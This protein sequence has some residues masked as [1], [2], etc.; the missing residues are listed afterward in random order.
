MI[1]F[2]I[3]TVQYPAAWWQSLYHQPH[4]TTREWTQE[5]SISIWIQVDNTPIVDLRCKFLFPD[6]AVQLPPIHTQIYTSDKKWKRHRP[7]NYPSSEREPSLHT[8]SLFINDW[9]VIIK[10]VRPLNPFTINLK[11]RN[12]ELNL[13][14]VYNA[15]GP[16]S[17][18]IK[19]RSDF[20]ESVSMSAC[21]TASVPTGT[22]CCNNAPHRLGSEA[23]S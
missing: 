21:E 9:K 20:R 3:L 6:A 18:S 10:K 22:S 7:S 2:T 4:G 17:C 5:L 23:S 8:L 14:R 15:H 1:S 12:E 16:H 11:G 13:T 19:N